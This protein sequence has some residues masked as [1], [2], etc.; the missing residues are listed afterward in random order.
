MEHNRPTVADHEDPS[1]RVEKLLGEPIH[2]RSVV[3]KTL[4]SGLG[5]GLLFPLVLSMF[6]TS[7]QVPEPATILVN[8]LR[9]RMGISREKVLDLYGEGDYAAA[10]CDGSRLS[11]VLPSGSG[12]EVV[13]LTFGSD[14][15]LIDV[16]LW[17]PPVSTQVEGAEAAIGK[18]ASTQV[19]LYADQREH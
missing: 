6:A 16:S 12:L 19:D 9:D 4:L 8:H 2:D 5:A 14:L 1:M 7:R 3:L 10:M 18:A 17:H 13:E 15:R 11:Y